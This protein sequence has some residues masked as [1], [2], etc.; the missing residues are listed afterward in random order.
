[1]TAIA[2]SVVTEITKQ[3]RGSLW[4]PVASFLFGAIMVAS[5]LY[6]YHKYTDVWQQ[7][8]MTWSAVWANAAMLYG[9]LLLPI[10]LGIYAAWSMRMEH[11]TGSIARLRA[12]GLGSSLIL[13]KVAGA[14]AANLIS[15]LLLGATVTAVGLVTGFSIDAEYLRVLAYLG[16]GLLG[17]WSASCIFLVLACVIR[18]FAVVCGVSV[19]CAISGF[20]IMFVAP[21]KQWLW[22]F[23]QISLGMHGRDPISLELMPTIGFMVVNAVI[24]VVAATLATR[25]L[26]KRE[27]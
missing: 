6:S 27:G 10:L 24:I 15:C 8:S 3:R 5:G 21:G 23:S 16:L 2:P 14:L 11:S 1:M 9:G 25:V 7:Q 22:P 19:L 20:G 12:L 13:G 4:F 26:G 17:G 18:S